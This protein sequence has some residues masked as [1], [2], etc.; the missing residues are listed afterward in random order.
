MPT[1][2]RCRGERRGGGGERFDPRETQRQLRVSNNGALREPTPSVRAPWKMHHVALSLLLAAALPA[3]AADAPRW[4]IQ[5]QLLA[6]AGPLQVVTCSDAALSEVRFVAGVPDAA[7]FRLEA[8]R[9][10]DGEL[11]DADG[12]LSARDWRAGECLHT[13]IDLRRASQN[14]G[15]GLQFRAGQYF[16]LDPRRWLWRPTPRH[17]D[18][19]LG[20]DLPPGWAVSVPWTPMDGAVKRYRLGSQPPDGPALMAF[21]RFEEQHIERPGGRLRVALLPPWQAHDLR[22]IEPVA[23]AL[24]QAFGRLPRRDAQVLVL[25]LP[26]ERDAA[27]WGQTTRGEAPAV[28][29]FVGAEAAPGALLEDWTATHEFAHLLHPHLGP[30]GRWLSEGLASYYQ[31]VLRARLGALPAAE[32]WERLDA[33]LQR[34]RDDARSR[35]MSLVQASRRLDA[36]RS[37]MRIYWSGAAFWM[38][39]DF[40]LRTAGDSLDRVLRRFAQ[41]CLERDAELT[42]EAFVAQLDRL[43][44][45]D[46]FESRYQRFAASVE[47]PATRTSDA[48]VAVRAAI[49]QVKEQ[50]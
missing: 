48:P 30:R 19:E 18:S 2:R 24:L 16:V 1:A 13:R 38:E 4:R 8:R 32:A 36:T 29:L 50:H 11:V 39:A 42:P 28:Q 12:S 49:M 35:G 14:G 31:N 6:E 44:G 15:R 9:D 21:G 20:F 47:F 27:P 25:P 45:R 37:Y 43:A 22:R 10:G 23:D 40:D 3:A 34:G 41:C 5:A 7:R 46:V 33:G 17:P 26:G